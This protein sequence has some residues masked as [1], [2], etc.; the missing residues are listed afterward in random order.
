[1]KQKMIYIDDDLYNHLKEETNASALI[2]SLL[3][4]Y[5]KFNIGTSEEVKARLRNLTEQ[6]SSQIEVYKKEIEKLEEVKKSIDVKEESLYVE[7]EYKKKKEN[8]KKLTIENNFFEIVNRAMT[9][10]EY[11][12]FCNL[13]DAD[14][15]NILDYANSKY[16]KEVI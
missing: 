6:Q 1:M 5:Y 7:E 4:Q 12:E 14:L 11:I 2:T 10:A 15:T 9:D 16:L 8:S 3:E 13:F